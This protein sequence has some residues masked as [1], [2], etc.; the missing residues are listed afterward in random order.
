MRFLCVGHCLTAGVLS[1]PVLLVQFAPVFAAGLRR[2]RRR[3]GHGLLPAVDLLSGLALARCLVSR[4]HGS[5]RGHRCDLCSSTWIK[6]LL[7]TSPV[8]LGRYLLCWAVG[9]IVG[10]A[11]ENPLLGALAAHRSN[12]FAPFCASCERRYVPDLLSRGFVHLAFLCS[13]ILYLLAGGRCHRWIRGRRPLLGHPPRIGQITSRLSMPHATSA[14]SL[15][16][17]FRGL[18]LL[19]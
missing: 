19:L 8:L 15:H 10:F 7:S 13:C 3:C 2:C 1:V 17:C 6:R 18:V 9:A 4:F 16:G 11:A 14:M 5:L 12:H